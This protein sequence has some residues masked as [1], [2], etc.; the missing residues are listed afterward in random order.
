MTGPHGAPFTP[1][2]KPEGHGP[3]LG[4]RRGRGSLLGHGRRAIGVLLGH[5]RRARRAPLGHRRGQ[6][7][8]KEMVARVSEPH[9][10]ADGCWGAQGLS[11]AEW[12]CTCS[13]F[14]PWP[15]T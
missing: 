9:L 4:Y 15:F 11:A 12:G 7:T 6:E 8:Q 5:G 14:L 10:V 2:L 13:Q 1:H 3:P